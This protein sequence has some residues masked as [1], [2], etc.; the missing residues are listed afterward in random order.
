MTRSAPGLG[1]VM[2]LVPARSGSERLPGKNLRHVG[3]VPL[4]VRAVST[5]LAAFGRVL[6]STDSPEY[7][8]IACAAGG[9]VPSLRPAGIAGSRTPMD[10]VVRHAARAWGAGERIFVL[11][12]PTAPFLEVAHLKAVV[13][14]LDRDPELGCAMTA[15]ALPS[16][17]GYAMALD[18]RH[19][20]QMLKPEWNSV[21]SQDLPALVTPSGGA[22]AAA[23]S[24]L[25]AGGDLVVDPIGVVV[26]AGRAAIDIDEE[27]DLA[28]ARSYA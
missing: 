8:K 15:E 3:G 13:D 11:M 24:R 9:T 14:M 23:L 25:C 27:A 28:L 21:R 19:R 2:C 12:Q 17:A 16:K 26:L 20:A 1:E 6:V 7:A 22:Y 4:L 5:A 18:A 10:H